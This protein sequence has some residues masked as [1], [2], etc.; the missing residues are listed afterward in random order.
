VADTARRES[1]ECLA[2]PRLREVELLDDERLT[3]LLE[4]GGADL[5]GRSP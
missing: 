1:D 3:E 5:H 2:L 4:D